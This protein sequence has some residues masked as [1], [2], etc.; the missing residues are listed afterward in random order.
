MLAPSASVRFGGEIWQKDLGLVLR[1]VCPHSH[2]LRV[3]RFLPAVHLKGGRAWGGQSLFECSGEL[4]HFQQD[5]GGP[6][7]GVTGQRGQLS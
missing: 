7:A 6:R 5:P 4:H 1:E 2:F 3:M